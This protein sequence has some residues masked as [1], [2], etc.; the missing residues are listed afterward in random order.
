[1]MKPTKNGQPAS[2]QWYHFSFM[3]VL[4]PLLALVVGVFIEISVA[5]FAV[6]VLPRFNRLSRHHGPTVATPPTRI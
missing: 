3:K 1:M 2:N 4:T 5:R 6:P